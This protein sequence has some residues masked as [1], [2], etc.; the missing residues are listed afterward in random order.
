[1]K[2]NK[3]RVI[4]CLTSAAVIA[5]LVLAS[6]LTPVNAVSGY[7]DP[8]DYIDD[9]VINGDT[10]TVYYDFAG[11]PWLFWFYDSYSG[12]STMIT[13][14]SASYMLVGATDF[15]CYAQPFGGQPSMGTISGGALDVSDIIPGSSIDFD[16]EFT[17]GIKWSGSDTED[18]TVTYSVVV[19]YYDA[20]G[21]YMG[22]SDIVRSSDIF[23]D[24]SSAGYQS[25]TKSLTGTI[26]VNAHYIIPSIVISCDW[27]D[28][29][30]GYGLTW[31]MSDCNFTMAVDISMIQE[32]SNLM[33]SV[34]GKLDE[35]GDKIDDTNDKLDD[36]NDKL[37]NIGDKIDDT[38]DKLDDIIT[39]TPEQ[40]ASADSF[41]DSVSDR[42]DA[43]QDALDTMD[44]VDQPDIS[45]MDVSV[46]T[47]VPETSMLAYTGPILAFWNNSTLK[48]MLVMVV[49]LALVSFVF[50]GKK[51]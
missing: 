18:V 15:N 39:G 40:N 44:S 38:N 28:D 11:V 19:Y 43:M 12:S 22:I 8:A 5:T 46:D 29:G 30:V 26:P 23:D 6:V 49:S 41:K 10:K 17:V 42:A 50:F 36:A 1:M 25:V 20:N 48:G 47:F 27:V 31:Y 35:L 33:Q 14:D 32:Q 9:V 37:D 45:D 24:L 13:G 7:Y 21:A 34:N 4:K 51:G 16:T 3:K 2:I